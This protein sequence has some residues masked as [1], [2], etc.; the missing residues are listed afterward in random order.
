LKNNSLKLILFMLASVLL[1]CR[2]TPHS[3]SETSKSSVHKTDKIVFEYHDASV[4]PDDHRSYMIALNPDKLIYVVD[5]YGEIIKKDS[6]NIEPNKWNE[7]RAAFASCGIKNV[8]ERKNSEGCTGGSGNSI[9]LYIN[10]E[11]IFSGYQYRCSTFFD[12]DLDGDLNCFLMTIK[13]D[14][15]PVFFSTD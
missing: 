13:Q 5:S 1:S 14:I 6:I 7:V 8:E 11:K 3:K 15:D 9:H 4:P 2:T 10:N 12:G